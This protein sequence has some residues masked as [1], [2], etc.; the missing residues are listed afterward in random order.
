MRNNEFMLTND[1]YHRRIF[2]L[3][4][5]RGCQYMPAV[6]GLNGSVKLT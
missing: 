2:Q 1:V 5:D 4:D 3:E 6:I